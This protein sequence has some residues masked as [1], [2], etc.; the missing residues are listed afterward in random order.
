MAITLTGAGSA[1]FAASQ[2]A[3]L[4]PGPTSSTEVTVSPA[5]LTART[6]TNTAQQG[7]GRSL[8]V[9]I[10]TGRVDGVYFVGGVETVSTV[11]T[12]TTTEPPP[13]QTI[14][15]VGS[16]AGAASQAASQWNWYNG[17][18]T[19]TS[20]STTETEN[21]TMAGYVLA[22]DP[23]E[24]GY[25]LIRLEIDGG[26]VYD[27]E[28]GIPAATTFRFYG[29]RHTST[30]EIL[31]EIIGANTGA[32]K[33]FV[34]VFIDGYPADSPPGVSAVI[35]NGPTLIAS[36]FIDFVNQYA[37]LN[38]A[39]V[40]WASLSTIFT[41]GTIDAGGWYGGS[42]LAGGNG[43]IVG[44]AL[45]VFTND[46]GITIVEEYSIGQTYNLSGQRVQFNTNGLNDLFIN[47]KHLGV[48][49]QDQTGPDVIYVGSDVAGISRIAVSVDNTNF[50]GSQNG[51]A[52]VSGNLGSP[53]PFST[54]SGTSQVTV[55]TANNTGTLAEGARLRSIRV[56]P[57]T[58]P[59]DLPSLSTVG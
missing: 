48:E 39:E 46:A 8:P 42:G 10:G 20:T 2:A 23:F 57:F 30:D 4:N 15:V 7:L 11:T 38:S 29:G 33:N 47:P 6:D 59:A 43:S 27:S 16:T 31:T 3:W 22:Y 36:L 58:A 44:D 37:E 25:D 56:G 45:N 51:S 49:I 12:E 1:S 24:R 17:G 52:V 19:T 18:S 21:R 9:V 14:V 26:V 54:D 34:M 35:S 40:P 28:A 41:G 5:E 55:F 13:E 32:Y 50:H 53:P